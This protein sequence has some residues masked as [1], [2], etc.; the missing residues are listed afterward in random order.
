MYDY[1]KVSVKFICRTFWVMNSDMLLLNTATQAI[2]KSEWENGN[3]KKKFITNTSANQEFL[4]EVIQ[5]GGVKVA[6][7]L[8]EGLP[9]PPLCLSTGKS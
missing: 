8:I 3:F 9:A 5:H 1:A 7:R 4:T 2:I 6:P